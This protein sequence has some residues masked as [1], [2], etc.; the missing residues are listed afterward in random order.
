MRVGYHF[1][2][3]SDVIGENKAEGSFRPS[4][5]QPEWRAENHPCEKHTERNMIK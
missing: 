3:L 4:T 2:L 5:R 1:T